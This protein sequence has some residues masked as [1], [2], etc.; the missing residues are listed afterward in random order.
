MY[1]GDYIR[2]PGTNHNGKEYKK[3]MHILINLL[4][5]DTNTTL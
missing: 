4:Y 1:K 2:Y 5:S 3:R